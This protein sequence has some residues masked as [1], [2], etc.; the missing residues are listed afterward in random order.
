MG[1]SLFLLSVVFVVQWLSGFAGETLIFVI[2]AIKSKFQG[3]IFRD[4][5]K[6]SFRGVRGREYVRLEGSMAEMEPNFVLAV[7]FV[8]VIGLKLHVIFELSDC[9]NQSLVK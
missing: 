8:E 6:I 5:R 1:R 7:G 4:C 2:L 9:L 3:S